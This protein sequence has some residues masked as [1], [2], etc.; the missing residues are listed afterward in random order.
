MPLNLLSESP[1]ILICHE[2]S[3]YLQSRRTYTVNLTRFP[4]FWFLTKDDIWIS[5]QWK[6]DM[7][8]SSHLL[9][10]INPTKSS[11][12]PSSWQYNWSRGKSR[13]HSSRKPALSL[14][15]SFLNKSRYGS[16]VVSNSNSNP[17]AWKASHMLCSTIVCLKSWYTF[18]L[19][20]T[21]AFSSPKGNSYLV[22]HL[23]TPNNV[24]SRTWKT[25]AVCGAIVMT[26]TRASVR[27]A[28]TSHHWWR[29]S[30]NYP[31]ISSGR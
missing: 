23:R 15:F 4:L 10:L 6:I 9:W 24:T 16:L 11:N 22:C 14:S 28:I 12:T 2:Q 7:I 18:I 19:K 1:I 29:D 8:E 20:L 30:G 5:D 17:S 27:R 21:V 31:S 26:R 13:C 3:K 25:W